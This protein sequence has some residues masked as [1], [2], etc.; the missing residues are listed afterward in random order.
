MPLRIE[1]RRTQK[2]MLRTDEPVSPAEARWIAENR[3]RTRGDCV[4][5][6]PCPFTSCSHNLA[7]DVLDGGT[8]VFVDGIEESCSLDVADRVGGA[9]LHPAEVARL[10]GR[11]RQWVDQVLANAMMHLRAVAEEDPIAAKVLR[12]RGRSCAL[13]PVRGTGWLPLCHRHALAFAN[14]THGRAVLKNKVPLIEAIGNFTAARRRLRP[15]V[16]SPRSISPPSDD[17]V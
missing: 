6:R 14:S 10:R 2:L 5:A 7:L 4:H 1:T 3:P 9:G 12:G 16:T 17:S 13:C 11:T 8:L 15:S